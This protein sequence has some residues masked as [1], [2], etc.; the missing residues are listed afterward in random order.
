MKKISKKR[1]LS[2]DS[3]KDTFE[4]NKCYMCGGITRR[5]SDASCVK[6]FHYKCMH[7]DI[8]KRK[9]Y[10]LTKLHQQARMKKIPFDI[11]VDDINWV[12]KCPILDYNLDYFSVGGK[13]YNTVS[14]DKKD[15]TKGYTKGNVFIVSN[16]ANSIKSDMNIQQLERLL[17]YVKN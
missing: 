12:D 8:E 3:E 9:K 10:L 6:C 1:Q 2:I 15:P 5:T 16:R 7:T 17:N 11:E 14:F 13:K 4:G